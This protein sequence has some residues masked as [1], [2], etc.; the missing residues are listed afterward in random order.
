MAGVTFRPT[1]SPCTSSPSCSWPACRRDRISSEGCGISPSVTCRV[2]RGY[3]VLGQEAQ[4][5]KYAVSPPPLQYT[6][7]TTHHQPASPSGY[8]PAQ[9]GQWSLTSAL[10]AAHLLAAL[11]MQHAHAGMHTL[12]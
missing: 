7:H 11:A 6:P 3:D 4:D 1:S 9:E 8:Q 5:H 12:P 2:Q 10:E